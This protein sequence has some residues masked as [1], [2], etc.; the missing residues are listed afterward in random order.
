MTLCPSDYVVDCSTCPVTI[1]LSTQHAHSLDG[2]HG[3]RFTL[4]TIH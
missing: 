2:F 3:V 1:T 4:S